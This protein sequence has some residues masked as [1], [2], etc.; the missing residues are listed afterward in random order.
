MRPIVPKAESKDLVETYVPKVDL[1]LNLDLTESLDCRYADNQVDDKLL[2]FLKSRLPGLDWFVDVGANQGLY[3]CFVLANS[4]N[5]Q[6]LAVEPDTYSTQ[7]MQLNL[8][9]N[10]L[11]RHRMQVCTDATGD[12]SATV[13]LMINDEGNRAGS[14]LVVDQRTFTGA[15]ENTVVEVT[16]R[17]LAQILQAFKVSG[18]WGMKMDIEGSEYS[19]LKEFLTTSK[20][21]ELP[22]FVI[23]E[24]FSHV[25][26]EV[27]GSPIELL[28]KAGYSLIEHE[29]HDFCFELL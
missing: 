1:W 4:V 9:S 25:I 18:R 28:I 17:P 2:A 5:I 20:P 26:A 3:S 12:T 16:Q 29:G 21:G 27:G 11:D 10:A 13:Q 23:V 6:V 8:A 14:S 24:A 19:T 15:Q 7:K 22:R